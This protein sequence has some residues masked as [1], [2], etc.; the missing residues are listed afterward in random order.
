MGP[1]GPHDDITP[2][3]KE[4]RARITTARRALTGHDT[5]AKSTGTSSRED[6]LIEE[7][8]R[9]Y[10]TMRRLLGLP[11]PDGKEW[12]HR[13]LRYHLGTA[14]LIKAAQQPDFDVQD[15]PDE[16]RR[17]LTHPIYDRPATDRELVAIITTYSTE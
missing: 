14:Y 4:A 17:M 9:R 12:G 2:D 8:G 10:L 7:N 5:H 16:L 15:V 13:M 3:L 11:E 1:R 6:G